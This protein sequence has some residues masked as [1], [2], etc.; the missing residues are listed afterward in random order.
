MAWT[1][2]AACAA[3]FLSLVL[4]V[5][6]PAYTLFLALLTVARSY[7]RNKRAPDGS[8]AGA[9]PSRR[10]GEDGLYTSLFRGRVFH[11]R[12]RPTVHSFGYPLHFA[13]V[14][15]GEAPGLWASVRPSGTSGRERA[16]EGLWPLS[17]LM[18]LRDVDHMKNGEGIPEGGRPGDVSLTERV[19]NLLRERTNGKFDPRP[20]DGE[21]R[22]KVVLVTHLM[23]YGY[24]F[25]P[26]S[27]YFVVR[28]GANDRDEDEI[29]AIVVEVSNT[30]WNEMSLYALH[31]DSIDILEHDVTR[32]AR[33]AAE[34]PMNTSIYR[35]K[36]RKNFHVS[37]FMTSKYIHFG[38]IGLSREHRTHPGPSPCLP[39]GSRLRLE[40]STLR[41]QDQSRDE[42]D[43]EARRDV[44]R[45]RRVLLGGLRRAADGH[46]VVDVPPA[47][48][49]GDMPISRLLFHH[50]G[51]DP[52]RGAAVTHEG[53]V[54][55]TSPRRVRDCSEQGD[56]GDDAA[57]LCGHG[58][59]PC[60]D[61]SAGKCRS[62]QNQGRIKPKSDRG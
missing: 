57:D 32:P 59:Y 40:V 3:A 49:P 13:V 12:H 4:V 55:H 46:A 14:D 54:L 50:T 9:S 5:I 23:Y 15:L 22:R 30:P 38:G 60:S 11:V 37:P 18:R 47:I 1:R 39:S 44:G 2:A 34:D 27:F 19:Y 24:C 7:R 21:H 28:T 58:V 56:R 36:W 61:G 31:P 25:N 42:D 33:G 17:T 51:L 53:R 16:G 10:P 45:G 48:R 6:L 8:S 62:R 20:A 26:V 35:Y 29:E 41:R 43:K 52:L